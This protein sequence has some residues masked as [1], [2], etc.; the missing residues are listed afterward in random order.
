MITLSLIFL[1]AAIAFLVIWLTGAI[2]SFTALSQIL[3]F[4]SGGLF[5][6]L[7][8]IGVFSKPPKV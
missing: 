1:V 6:L 8:I 4:V 3:F 5:L 2:V 7:L